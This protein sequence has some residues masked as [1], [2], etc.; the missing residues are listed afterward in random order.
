[1]HSVSRCRY[2][3]PYY[4]VSALCLS[5]AGGGV[6]VGAGNVKADPSCKKSTVTWV[7]KELGGRHL[8]IG[9]WPAGVEIEPRFQALYDDNKDMQIGPEDARFLDSVGFR[10]NNSPGSPV[11]SPGEARI[12]R[13]YLWMNA[14]ATLDKARLKTVKLYAR[15]C[16]GLA[17][18]DHRK[19]KDLEK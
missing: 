5:I 11:I 4:L 8:L 12:K 17:I 16:Y 18:Q 3:V 7:R 15:A 1:M 13:V 19:Y 9:N 2:F 10:S 14:P 6:A